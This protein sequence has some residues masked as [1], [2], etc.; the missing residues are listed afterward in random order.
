MRVKSWQSVSWIIIQKCFDSIDHKLLISKLSNY[1]IQGKELTWF[2]SYLTDRKQRVICNGTTSDSQT[3]NIGVPQGSILGPFLYLLFANDMVNFV[4]NGNINCF[5]DDTIL[6]TTGN[7]VKEANEKLQSCILE[8]EKWY[9]ANRLRVNASKSK[10]MYIGTKQRLNNENLENFSILYNGEKLEKVNEMKYLGIIIDQHLLWDKQCNNVVRNVAHKLSMMRRMSSVVP[11]GILCEVY[12]R[13]VQ[14]LIDYGATIWGQCSQ[15]Q[16]DRVQHMI[17]LIAR[18]VKK[19][20]D[21]INSRGA[22][23]A[24]SLG[25]CTFVQRRDYLLTSL[26]YK[27]IQGRAPSYLT[28]YI[29]FQHEWSVRTTRASTQNILHLPKHNTNNMKRSFN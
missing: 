12:K 2:K 25:W 8:L 24:K 28:D 17:N 4:K 27:C 9:R 21:F 6:Y 11:E 7:S 22:D 26:M 14:P 18:T 16:S 10:I 20:F 23:I 29:T 19:D 1:G 15:E 3:V 13:Y 5:A